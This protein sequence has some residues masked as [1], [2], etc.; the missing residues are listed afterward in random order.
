[1]NIA[2]L[3]IINTGAIPDTCRDW[4]RRTP[5]NQTWA[6]FRRKFARSQWE[7]RII[8]STASGEG[9]HTINVSEHYGHNSLLADSSVTS[10]AN[11]TTA[12]SSDHETVVTLTKSIAT[13][14][15]KLK[16]KDNW[17]KS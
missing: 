8:S 3:L 12:T 10:M 13:L 11:L 1:V 17:A 15:E 6:D 16:A 14:T 4:Q 5:L 7:H 9:Y 2:F